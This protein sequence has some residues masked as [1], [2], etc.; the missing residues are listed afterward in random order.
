MEV[1]VRKLPVWW[2]Q[3]LKQTRN[4]DH[5]WLFRTGCERWPTHRCNPTTVW[6]GG[7]CLLCFHPGPVR[8]SLTYL[9][10]WDSSMLPILTPNIA[11]IPDLHR[12]TTPRNPNLKPSKHPSLQVA[13]SQ[14]CATT[15]VYWDIRTINFWFPFLMSTFSIDE[16][17]G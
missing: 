8:F 10:N 1:N 6:H 9:E 17:R 5:V 3:N 14:A 2:K 16:K 13:R 12:A 4:R 15:P 7:F 11:R